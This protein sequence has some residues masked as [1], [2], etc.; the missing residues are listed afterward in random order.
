MA[1][2]HLILQI[3]DNC[4]LECAYCCLESGPWRKE[5]MPLADAIGYLEQAKALNPSFFLSFTGG[6]PFSRFPLMRDIA[7]HA[8]GLGIWHT[9]ITSA[10][11]CKSY[12][13][14]RKRLAELKE[15]GLRTVSISYD[16]YH[17]PWVSRD[18]IEHCVSAAVSL[19]L[20]VLV[21][22]SITKD[23][24]GA[25][26]LLSDMEARYPQIRIQDGAVQPTGRG[27]QI[28]IDQLL[29][30]DFA[31]QNL[32][33]PVKKDILVRP[34]GTAFPCCSTG[35]DY[36]YLAIGNAKSSTLREIRS[37]LE[38]KLWFKVI[39]EQGFLEL[40]A[41]VQTYFPEVEFP[42]RHIGVCHLCS[43][44]FNDK[45]LGRKVDEALEMRDI[46]VPP[47]VLNQLLAAVRA[48]L[49]P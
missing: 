31:D 46:G 19:D 24:R 12:E 25:K 5:T 22:G 3:T 2:D 21:A 9:T 34:E 23:S 15:Y 45:A 30:G 43:L 10:V 18:K 1:F 37:A 8:H 7:K 27:A 28:P 49:F 40:E 35:G 44:V 33:C 42:R 26:Q 29:T 17:E 39:T 6:E 41:I 16:S 11:W 14:T 4:P 36:A 20:Q 13:H 48:S 32:H 47:S 38:S